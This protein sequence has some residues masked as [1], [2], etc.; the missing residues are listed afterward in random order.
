VLHHHLLVQGMDLL[1]SLR[2]AII[3]P[4]TFH[5]RRHIFIQPILDGARRVVLVIRRG[6]DV[7]RGIDV[8]RG[9]YILTTRRLVGVEL[10]R[11]PLELGVDPAWF[12]E[13]V[14]CA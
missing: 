7:R 13:V 9:V 1:E 10:L 11:G 12:P 8:G 5:D 14:A 4:C 2:V 3:L 6:V